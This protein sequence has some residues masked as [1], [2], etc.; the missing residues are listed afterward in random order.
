MSGS[1]SNLLYLKSKFGSCLGLKTDTKHESDGPNI[2]G[3]QKQN[4]SRFPINIC[5]LDL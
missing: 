4:E 3:K 5:L 1:S 2:D